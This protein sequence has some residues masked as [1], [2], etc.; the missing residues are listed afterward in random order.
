MECSSSTNTSAI[1][2]IRQLI[3]NNDETKSRESVV[4][5]YIDDHKALYV[6]SEFLRI[7]LKNELS[8]IYSF[9]APS[10]FKAAFTMGL[11]ISDGLN[12]DF[13]AFSSVMDK[14]P[15][16]NFLLPPPIQ[17]KKA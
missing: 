9:S 15:A 16:L 13:V 7:L 2:T 8:T 11:G 6:D 4:N 10:R 12:F 17:P 14:V 1:P 3:L 5:Y